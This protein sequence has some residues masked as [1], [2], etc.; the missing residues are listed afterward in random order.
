MG[1]SVSKWA[2]LYKKLHK[3]PGLVISLLLLYYGVTGIFMN[4][5]EFFSGIDVS[6]NILPENFK[7][8]NWNNSAIKGNLIINNDSILVYGNIG[9]WLTDS[10]FKN[11]Q[12]F[13]AGFP[14]GMDNRKIF[15]LHRSDDG[16]LYATTLFGLFA[17]SQE[18]GQWSKIQI[19]VDIRRFV[20]ITTIYYK[21]SFFIGI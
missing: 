10:T 14:Q 16:N 12:S 20:A 3:W 1:N 2:K 13:N 7:Y 19:S 9:I 6:R 11:Y 4:H 21:Y 5:R 17:Y 8:H 15:D 18:E